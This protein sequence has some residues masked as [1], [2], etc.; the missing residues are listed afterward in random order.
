MAIDI[1]DFIHSANDTYPKNTVDVRFGGGYQYSSYPT[2]PDQIV[3]NC[4]FQ[5][6]KFY[7]DGSGNVTSAT[8]PRSNMRALQEF[9]ERNGTHKTFLYPHPVRGYI[10]AKFESP[11]QCP[12]LIKG[13]NGW[14]ESFE[15]RLILQP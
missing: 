15:L 9:Y 10:F 1:F 11:L 5:S 3:I 14:T 12:K 13:G 2:G 4:A 8:S 7:L 6:M